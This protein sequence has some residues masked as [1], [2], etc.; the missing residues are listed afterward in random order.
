[1]RKTVPRPY[2]RGVV[3]KEDPMSQPTGPERR[4]PG[5]APQDRS[6][7]AEEQSEPAVPPP[8]GAA[9]VAVADVLEAS[10]VEGEDRARVSARYIWFVVLAYLGGTVALVAPI[11]LSL[12]LRVQ[13][14]LP[15]NVE[16]LGYIIGAG[17]AVAALS[18]PLVGMWSD[19]TRSRFG[20]RRPFSLGGA[21]VGIAG[22]AVM[23]LAPDVWVLTLGWLITQLGWSNANM[24][25]LQSQ[26]DRLPESQRGKV[27]GLSGF[28]QMIGA[29]LGVGM[30]S[31]FIG[32]S[33]LVFLVPGFFGLLVMALWVVL[34]KED[35]SRPMP[36]SDR[37][38]A[39]TLL[40]GMVFDPRRHPDFAWNWLG[41][42][43]FN[44]GV[45]FATTFTTLFFASRL[46]GTGLVADIGG[47]IA[48]LSLVGVVA[49]AGGAMLGGWLS[50]KFKRRRVF[51]LLSGITFTVGA[52]IMAFG[53]S[54]AVLLIGG[55]VLTSVGLGVFSAVDQ[56][57]VLD[58][59]PDRDSS[60]GRFIGIN[61][62]ATSVAQSIA[63]IV[64]APLL[65]L[66]VSGTERNYGLLFLV[67][68]GC[69]LL[70]GAIITGKV[71]STR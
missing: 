10:V 16:V 14:L 37:L 50:D 60:A 65:L 68:A 36:T 31:A 53:G 64:A 25:L 38:T 56:A 3:I 6:V 13:E 27:A 63:P 17:A 28:V 35:D 26:A 51:V 4:H 11:G 21:L 44:F 30:A 7:P 45:T 58:V 20:R 48:A 62:Y 59:L 33:F 71:R 15:Q 52:V 70:G 55:S 34:V 40:R 1:V 66:G 41:R 43:I 5:D 49:T 57:I 69:T 19:R 8:H 22:L 32:S 39:G 46:S 29:V 47:L 24:S 18:A 12:S 61:Q 9:S 42:L 2:F 54:D 23:A 67:A